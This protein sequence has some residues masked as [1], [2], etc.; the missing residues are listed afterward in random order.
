M[1]TAVA[2]PPVSR[3][4]AIAI[5]E[6]DAVAAY[7]HELNMLTLEVALHDDGWHVEY[8]MRRPRWAGGGPHYLIDSAT[9]AILTKKY[10]Q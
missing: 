4:Q 9:G 2:S 3:Q 6:A 5:A 8:H 7:G 10:Y 1:P